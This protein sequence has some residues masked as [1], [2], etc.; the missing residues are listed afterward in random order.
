[1]RARLLELT[2]GFVLGVTSCQSKENPMSSGSAGGENGATA[3]GDSRGG[4]GAGTG[5]AVT[6]GGSSGSAGHVPSSANAGKSSGG[7]HGGDDAGAS[8]GAGGS[9]AAGDA[10]SGT[11]T[12]SAGEPSAGGDGSGAVTVGTWTDAPGACPPGSTRVDITT[13]DEME[14]A[15]RGESDADAT[16]FFVHDGTYAQTGSTLPLYF[17]RGGSVNA[18]VVWVGESRS[19][20]VIQGRATFE[21]GSDHMVLSNMT[22]DISNVTQTGAYDTVTVLAS[23]ITLTHL[24]LTGDCAH[25]SQGGHIEVPGQDDP[26]AP[27]QEHVVI[28]SCLIEK[29]GHCASGGSLDH[30]IYLSSGDDI[31]IRNSVIR[32][33]SSRGIQI[34]THYE[35]SSLT[36]T[37]ILVERNLVE[38]NGHGDYQDGM[39]INGNVDSNFAGPIDGVT[40]RNNVFWQNYYSAIRFVGNSVQNVAIEHNTFVDDGAESTSDNRS[41]LN[42]DDGT[43]SATA[44]GNLFAPANTVVNSCVASLHVSD[45]FVSGD[46]SEASC[47]SGSVSGEPAFNDGANGDFHPQDAVAAGYGAY[48]P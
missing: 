24:T 20:V 2:F 40:I 11:E 10:G 48:V 27:M 6:T 25:G 36:L 45:S 4:N 1:M 26:S 9:T 34:Y 31:V 14:S 38:S 35:D 18:P 28:D 42:L 22:L 37:N 19:G 7:G 13:L 5:G 17:E 33:N 39:V 47:V 46:A 23:D 15:S 30:G 43:P 8:G 32:A 41:E 21:V 16:C 12:G 29:F 44:T 3:G